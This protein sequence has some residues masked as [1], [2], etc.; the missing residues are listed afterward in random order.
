MNTMARYSAITA[1]RAKISLRSTP[2]TNRMRN[3]IIMKSRVADV[4]PFSII[5]EV[6]RIG[7]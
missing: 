6:S 3:I 1:T 5:P 7:M 4:P 2:P